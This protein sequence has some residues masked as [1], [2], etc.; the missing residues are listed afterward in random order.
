MSVCVLL[1]VCVCV[2]P[3]V[4][5]AFAR[6]DVIKSIQSAFPDATCSCCSDVTIVQVREKG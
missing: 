6:A 2:C 1:R 3:Q 4:C 5:D